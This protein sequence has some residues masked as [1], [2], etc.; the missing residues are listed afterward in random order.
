MHGNMNVKHI[1]V[2]DNLIVGFF[3]ADMG[4]KVREMFTVLC[5][6]LETKILSLNNES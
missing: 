6:Y 1:Q 4:G 5:R 2:V 3:C